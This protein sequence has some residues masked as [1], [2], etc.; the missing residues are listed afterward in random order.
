VDRDD[1]GQRMTN[2][3]ERQNEELSRQQRFRDQIEAAQRRD[4]LAFNRANID[5]CSN[6]LLARVR[7]PACLKLIEEAADR[8]LF[9]WI[10][11]D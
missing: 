8:K 4:G 7:D 9:G 6:A 10:S 3:Y 5:L 1:F 11:N 2:H